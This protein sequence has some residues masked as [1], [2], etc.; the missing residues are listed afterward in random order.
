MPFPTGVVV[1]FRQLI[2]KDNS[3]ARSVHLDGREVELYS[4]S[5]DFVVFDEMRT[6]L[7]IYPRDWVA[8]ILPLQTQ[9]PGINVADQQERYGDPSAP[10]P[11]DTKT[12]S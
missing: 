11:R 3:L 12:F 2:T 5:D 8:C 4:Q 7:G 10:A 1:F 9:G 6:I